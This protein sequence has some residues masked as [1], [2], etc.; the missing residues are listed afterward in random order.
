MAEPF[1]SL[2]IECDMLQNLCH[3]FLN[4]YQ[5]PLFQPIE[6]AQNLHEFSWGNIICFIVLDEAL[7]KNITLV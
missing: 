3:R 6:D 7:A 2:I 4:Y 1:S 5:L